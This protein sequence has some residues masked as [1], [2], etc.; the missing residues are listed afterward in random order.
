MIRVA[1]AIGLSPVGGRSSNPSP[2]G[3]SQGTPGGRGITARAGSRSLQVGDEMYLWLL[4]LI[5][6][7]TLA[8]LRNKFRRYH[9]G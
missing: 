7:F 4:V 8:A 2:S 6:V 9:G 5:E 1:R 3:V